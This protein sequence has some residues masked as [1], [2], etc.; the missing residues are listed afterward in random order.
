[1]SLPCL[2]E[3]KTASNSKF[4]I[5]DSNGEPLTYS[6]FQYA[7]VDLKTVQYLAEYAA[8]SPRKTFSS[9]LIV[10]NGAKMGTI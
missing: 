10:Q 2:R 8:L 3:V 4:V 7:G 6:Q 5:A 1:M 9:I